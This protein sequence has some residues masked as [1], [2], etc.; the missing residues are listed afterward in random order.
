MGSKDRPKKEAVPARLVGGSFKKPGDLP[1]RLILGGCARSRSS[2]PPVR[3]LKVYTEALTGF[4]HVYQM[5]YP[6]LHVRMVSTTHYCLKS[7][8]LRQLLGQVGR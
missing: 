5:V 3:I 7:V 4:S 2:H 8:F 1:M 6:V